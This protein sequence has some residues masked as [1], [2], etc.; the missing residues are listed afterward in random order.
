[1]V[2]SPSCML[3][4]APLMSKQQP[5]QGQGHPLSELPQDDSLV[6]HVDETEVNL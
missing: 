5:L 6:V 1:M 4:E 3:C 2:L